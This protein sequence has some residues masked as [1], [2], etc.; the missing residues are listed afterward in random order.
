[1][2]TVAIIGAGP[3]GL[4]AAKSALE[5]GLQ[6]TVFE[7]GSKLGGL[8]REVDD[9]GFTWDSLCTNLA[10]ESCSFSD[11]P[12]PDGTRSHPLRNEVLEY[13]ERYACAFGPQAYIRFD[14]KV[15]RVVRDE[16]KNCWRVTWLGASS[17]EDSSTM[18]TD[19]FSFVMVCSGIFSRPRY[20]PFL[21]AAVDSASESSRKV[22]PGARKPE[23][24]HSCQYRNPRRFANKRVLV[25]G[26]AFS[27]GEIAA[28][29]A[30]ARGA[31]RVVNAVGRRRCWYIHR[32]T[33]AGIPFD[34]TAMTR[35]NAATRVSAGLSAKEERQFFHTALE[36][37]C[38]LNPGDVSPVLRIDPE[39]DAP[40]LAISDTFLDAVQQCTVHV[41]PSLVAVEGSIA[42]FSDGSREEI[43]T[44]LCATGF[45][46]QL[47]FFDEQVLRQIEFDCEDSLLPVVMYKDVFSP[48]LPNAA[49]IG[50]ERRVRFFSSELEARWVCSVFSGHVPAPDR[51]EMEEELGKQ[52]ALRNICPRPQFVRGQMVTIADDYARLCGVQPL[53]RRGRH[54]HRRQGALRLADQWALASS[55]FQAAR[56]KRQAGPGSG[57]DSSYKR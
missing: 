9:H 12:W 44:I 32:C 25:V 16:E 52:R 41:K 53:V 57:H 50:V 18:A 19:S 43:D 49:F 38:G 24:L 8:W 17:M 54:D 30:C 51:E 13:L 23:I 2:K 33:A 11:F 4:V 6:P 39:T 36:K 55:P 1:M 10:A 42:I 22:Q 40:F 14:C 35:S 56:T 21:R 34:L 27:G 47:P 7:Q 3:S 29:I 45:H 46:L 28:E 48:H 26:S 15:E 31:A 20:P 37:A 5:L